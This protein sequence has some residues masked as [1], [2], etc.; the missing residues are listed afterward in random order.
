[1]STLQTIWRSL[2]WSVLTDILMRVLPA[3]LCIT[4]HELAHGFVA[5][6]LGDTTA[7]DLGRLSLNPLHHLDWMGLATM[8]VFRFG[9]AKPVP[10]N[11]YRFN[12]PKRGM[13]ITALAGPLSS[14]LL[15]VLM[16]VLYGVCFP[17]RFKA[18]GGFL[19]SL[20]VSTAY[21]SLSLALFNLIPV[22]PLDGSK[23]LFSLLSDKAY[24]KLMKVERYGM[25]VLVA[26]LA[27]GILRTPLSS[28]T[29]WIFE[30]I[31]PLAEKS[32]QLVSRWG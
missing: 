31:L 32:Y 23:V 16:L 5:L 28:A 11:M 21:L 4:F 22:P 6:C 15:C 14:F 1:M 10:I 27:T 24:I 25:L 3:L 2:D 9:W 18:A 17:L 20:F 29:E 19:L 26:L 30:R 13:A 12:N 8:V 7:R